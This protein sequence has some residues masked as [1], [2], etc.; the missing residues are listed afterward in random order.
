MH[1]YF[2]AQYVYYLDHSTSGTQAMYTPLRSITHRRTLTSLTSPTLIELRNISG[3]D[4]LV[5]SNDLPTVEI[6]S[7]IT[8]IALD[9][10]KS[11][12]LLWMRRLR[13]IGLKI[14]VLWVG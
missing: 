3:G 11:T 13:E 1:D 9:D 2:L 5:A 8:G 6:V 10:F 12:P 4:C 14:A 7:Y